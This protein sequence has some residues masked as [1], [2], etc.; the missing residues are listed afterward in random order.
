[1]MNDKT[2]E[3]QNILP[4]NRLIFGGL[5]LIGGFL[6]PL[7]IP[8]VLSTSWSEGLKAIISGLLAFGIPELFMIIAVGIMGKQGLNHILGLLGR[9]LKPIA[10]PDE[11]SKPRYKIGIV[12]FFAPIIYGFLEPYIGHHIHFIEENE[13]IFYISGDVMLLLSLFVLGGNFWDKIR[14]LFIHKSK[15]VFPVENT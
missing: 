8:W 5:I 9:W 11:V 12:M 1:M 4:R 2:T 14:S 6:S 13:L 3:Y 15:S 7:L 10:P